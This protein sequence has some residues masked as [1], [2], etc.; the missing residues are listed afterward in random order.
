ML[1]YKLWDRP[2]GEYL[3]GCIGYGE[4]TKDGGAIAFLLNRE[5]SYGPILAQ[6]EAMY[7]LL[8]EICDLGILPYAVQ[9]KALS[10]IA[11]LTYQTET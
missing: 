1:V 9:M 8:K 6:S 5:C 2:D 10:I 3:D 11:H 7:A 4:I